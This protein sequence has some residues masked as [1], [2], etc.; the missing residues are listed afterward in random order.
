ML[1]TDFPQAMIPHEAAL[2]HIAVNTHDPTLTR[3]LPHGD[4]T[5]V[6]EYRFFRLVHR[7]H[8]LVVI[9]LPHQMLIVEIAVG[10][11]ERLLTIGGF[12]KC[13]EPDE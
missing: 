1:E 6:D 12:Y 2:V 3:I 7:Y 8:E 10:I 9:N 11:D 13:Q 5:S 4:I